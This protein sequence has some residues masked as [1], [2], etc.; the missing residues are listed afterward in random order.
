MFDY[1]IAVG[2]NIEP[3]KNIQRAFDLLKQRVDPQ[4]QIAPLLPT[5]AEGDPTQPDY[6]NTAFQLRSQQPPT[7]LKQAL[8]VI[9]AQL[10]RVRTGNKNAAR[11][12]DLDISVCDGN[13]IDDDYYGYDFVK[14]SVDFF[15]R[16][17]G[18]KGVR[19]L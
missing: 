4:V 14:R 6:L 2:S 7:A 17:G 3:E 10:Q 5:R 13:I 15:R 8:R 1:I 18:G 19:A 11:T 16:H 12:I 9:E